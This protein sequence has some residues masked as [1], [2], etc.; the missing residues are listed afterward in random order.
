MTNDDRLL[1]N[2]ER[3][4]CDDATCRDNEP[5]AAQWRQAFDQW[6]GRHDAAPSSRLQ[7]MTLP[8]GRFLL[9]MDQCP[10]ALYGEKDVSRVCRDSGATGIMFVPG[11]VDA[12]SWPDQDF[13]D[14]TAAACAMTHAE[15]DDA[16]IGKVR[17]MYG[18][19]MAEAEAW[20]LSGRE[21]VERVAVLE[22]A[23]AEARGRLK[24]SAYRTLPTVA[25]ALA[26]LVAV[27]AA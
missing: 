8:N 21:A 14:A 25:A 3:C 18:G 27:D 1:P 16:L 2:G 9:V 26:A 11:R 17:G 24:V 22:E 6:D 12:V 15:D 23:L 19:M 13:A 4:L 5:A 10:T 20:R 7:V